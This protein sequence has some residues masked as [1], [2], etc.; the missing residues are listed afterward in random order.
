MK[1]WEKYNGSVSIMSIMKAANI[2]WGDLPKLT[3]YTNRD[4]NKSMLCY[5][6]VLG[7]CSNGKGC[8]Y[9][10]GHAPQVDVGDEFAI[11]LCKVLEPGVRWLI[12]NTAAKSDRRPDRTTSGSPTKIRK[13][14]SRG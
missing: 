11:A 2:W 9:A 10:D 13:T 4:D 3:K 12:V 8:H 14:E 1:Y 7:Q 5:N 6:H